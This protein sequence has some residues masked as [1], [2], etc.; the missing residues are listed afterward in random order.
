MKRL[1]LLATAIF[2]STAQLLAAEHSNCRG[3]VVDEQGEPVIGATITIPGT[4]IGT[5]TNIDGFSRLKCRKAPKTLRSA[6]SATR[7]C[8]KSRKAIWAKFASRQHHRC[9]AT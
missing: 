1:L 3:R 9:S 4:K 5:V 2:L 8:L 6:M 7:Q